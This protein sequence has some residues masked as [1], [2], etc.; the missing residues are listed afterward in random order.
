[1]DRRN[2]IVHRRAGHCFVLMAAVRSNVLFALIPLILALISAFLFEGGICFAAPEA[3]PA[4]TTRAPD[5]GG[6]PETR[7]E[8]RPER[9]R[10]AQRRPDT[11]LWPVRM[12]AFL[13]AALSSSPQVLEQKKLLELSQQDEWKRFV[14]AEPTLQY[15]TTD[16]G[17]A[18]AWGL[19]LPIPF[20][21]KPFVMSQLDH[22]RT[23]GLRLEL[24]ARSFETAKLAIQSYVDCAQAQQIDLLTVATLEDLETV[25]NT[26][27]RLYEEGHSTQAEK[28]G[29]ELQVHQAQ[30]DAQTAREKTE[31]ACAKLSRLMSIVA[32]Q[33]DQSQVSDRKTLRDSSHELAQISTPDS[34]ENLRE[35]PSDAGER[36]G[37]YPRLQLDDDLSP[38][39]LER[40]GVDSADQA[41]AKASF[42]IAQATQA[43]AFWTQVPDFNVSVTRNH[44]VYLPGSPS[45]EANTWSYGVSVT[46]PL[47][48]PIQER[49][50]VQK[51]KAQARMDANTANLARITAEADREDAALEYKRSHRRLVELRRNDLNLAEALVESTYSAYRAGKLGYAEL[52]L[53]RKTL[54]DLRAQDIQ[55]RASILVS[56]LRCLDRCTG[57]QDS[58]PRQ[59]SN[60]KTSRNF[61]LEKIQSANSVASSQE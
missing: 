61:L 6:S 46:L 43:T 9:P 18:N 7:P 28:I 10:D 30:M 47:L 23:E 5:P 24:R 53:S 36:P 13:D 33:T 20:P 58:V 48:F 39:I 49:A 8:T 50:E 40:L 12:D 21:L 54:A 38:Q 57:S 17:T 60:S 35:N 14:I 51:L 11:R 52:V 27:K 4:P 26:L 56:R 19:S 22:S 3:F 29:S 59:K 55:L 37:A 25:S 15:N 31:V 34:S 41:R 44:Y 42:H 1:M 2:I 16:N 45:G 32:P